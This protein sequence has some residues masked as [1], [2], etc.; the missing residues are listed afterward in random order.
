MN[1]EIIKATERATKLGEQAVAQMELIEDLA[2]QLLTALKTYEEIKLSGSD[3]EIGE[4]LHVDNTIRA[5]FGDR[6]SN[7]PKVVEFILGA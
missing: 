5:A 2:G 6:E 7:I 4:L 3:L 1:A